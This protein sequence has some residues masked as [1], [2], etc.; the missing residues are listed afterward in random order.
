MSAW[1]S[2]VTVDG[3]AGAH[4]VSW[5]P[6]EGLATPGCQSLVVTAGQTTGVVS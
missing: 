5:E 3:V 1:P 4:E 6:V 2:T